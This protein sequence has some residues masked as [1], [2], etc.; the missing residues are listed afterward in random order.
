MPKAYIMSTHF[1][2]VE[3]VDVQRTYLDKFADVDHRR[4]FAVE[5]IDVSNFAPNEETFSYSGDHGDALDLLAQEA[6]KKAGPSDWL[7]FLDSDAVPIAPLSKILGSGS[8]FVAVQRLEHLGSQHPH[9]C[10]AAVRAKT[11]RDLAPSWKN[12]GHHWI[13]EFG[14]TVSDVG[15]GFIPSRTEKSQP[16][17]PLRKIS[18]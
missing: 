4:M 18:T 7:V 10:F 2:A 16:W 9:P 13:D 15:S 3:W 14:R 12:G 5:G 8:D 11:Y 6:L 17:L 1:K